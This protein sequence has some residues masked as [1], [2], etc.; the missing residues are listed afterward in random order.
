MHQITALLRRFRYNQRYVV[1]DQYELAGRT[2][3]VKRTTVFFGTIWRNTGYDELADS[4]PQSCCYRT[5]MNSVVHTAA[6]IL[7]L[8]RQGLSPITDNE[9]A[10]NEL[11]F[12][13]AYPQIGSGY[14]STI[15]ERSIDYPAPGMRRLLVR[16]RA[17]LSPNPH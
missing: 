4:P 2:R 6:A 8:L 16:Q 9:D 13:R 17:F 5:G 7:E 10:L 1:L 14:E 12:R 3:W 15:W 11:G